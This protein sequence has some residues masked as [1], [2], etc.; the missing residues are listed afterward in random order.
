M[1][2]LAGAWQHKAVQRNAVRGTL[3]SRSATGS[4]QRA[5][6]AALLCGTPARCPAPFATNA[7]PVAMMRVAAAA[8]R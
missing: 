2:L 7:M 5:S 1:L 3:F 6:A 4:A 8:P